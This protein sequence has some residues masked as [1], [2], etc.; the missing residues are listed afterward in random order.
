MDNIKNKLDL[1]YY[2]N[3]KNYI[4]KNNTYDNNKWIDQVINY[5]KITIE[6]NDNIISSESINKDSDV[7]NELVE[8]DNNL[9]KKPWIK[10]NIIHKFLK[11][12][13]YINDLNITNT[14]EKETLIELLINLVKNKLLT[15]KKK[16]LYDE[17]NGKIISITELKYINGKY[18][19][20]Q[21]IE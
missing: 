4:I 11:I 15:K 17:I 7:Q 19:Y 8:Y 2:N 14:D 10:L 13:E 18:Y 16:V 20:Q 21:N 3:I 5:N 1:I 12:K 9:Y 6:N